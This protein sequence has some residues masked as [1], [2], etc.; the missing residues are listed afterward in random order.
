MRKMRTRPAPPAAEP[1]AAQPAPVRRRARRGTATHAGDA[2]RIEDARQ[3][4]KAGLMLISKAHADMAAAKQQIADQE[5]YIEG[6]MRGAKLDEVSEG[7]Y[8][9]KI[10]TKAGRNSKVIDTALFR[11]KVS[12]AVFMECVKVQVGTVEEHL[13]AK[14]ILAVSTTVTGESKEVFEV[15]VKKKK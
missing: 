3:A 9:A 14:E 7:I 5:A 8:T 15:Q 12:D 11:K 2:Q 1:E 10:Y 6:L 13:S 4:V